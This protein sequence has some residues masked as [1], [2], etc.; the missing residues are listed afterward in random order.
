MDYCWKR[1]TSQEDDDIVSAIGNNGI[2]CV[3]YAHMVLT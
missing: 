3:G 1:T 2:T